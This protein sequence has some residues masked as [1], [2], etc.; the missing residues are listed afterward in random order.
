MR[1]ILVLVLQMSNIL[2][3]WF[4]NFQLLRLVYPRKHL[5]SY[6]LP[7]NTPCITDLLLVRA[8]NSFTDL[9][10]VPPR[11]LIAKFDNHWFNAYMDFLILSHLLHG[12]LTNH[13][14]PAYVISYPWTLQPGLTVPHGAQF[15]VA[16]WA[17]SMWGWRDKSRVHGVQVPVKQ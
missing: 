13:L 14:Q 12:S 2:M 3:Q 16:R 8:E 17:V 9:F 4:P 11:A 10:H 6:Q 15:E 1:S 5:M 7:L